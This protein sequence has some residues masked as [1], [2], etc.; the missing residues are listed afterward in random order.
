[1]VSVIITTYEGSKYIGRALISVLNQTYKDLEVIVVDDNIEESEER[2]RTEKVI[3]TISDERVV[4][5][6][7]QQHIN[8]AYARNQ[9]IHIARGE[10]IA[11]LDDDDIFCR[12]RVEECV[13]ILEKENE[14]DAVYSNVVIVTNNRM[15]ATVKAKK[16]GMLQKNLILN[17]NMLGTG[18]NLF[19]T[20]R[21]V[22][23]IGDFDES[24]VRYQDV[25]FMVRFF[26][27][28]KIANLEKYLVVKCSNGGKNI[29]NYKKMI[30]VQK[31]FDSKYQEQMKQ[32]SD[33]DIHEYKTNEISEV[34]SEAI[35]EN[36]KVSY[37]LQIKRVLENELKVPIKGKMIMKC[38]IKKHLQC[39]LSCKYMFYHFLRCR[40]D[41]LRE[42]FEQLLVYGGQ[43]N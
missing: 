36:F 17:K 31:K 18:S 34:Y 38:Y 32:F 5:L 40:N 23:K 43:K 21:A 28:F 41:E 6:K 15:T 27:F 7:N 25:E 13:K 10:Y 4:Y 20:R 29:P 8:G 16:S 26:D 2:I 42:C 3:R 24:F 19:L 30:E 39:I 35:K 37:M 14:Y 1:M 33:E 9:G 11:F 22:Q 12:E